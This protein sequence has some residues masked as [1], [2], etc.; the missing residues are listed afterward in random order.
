MNHEGTERDTL[1]YVRKDSCTSSGA[2]QACDFGRPNQD[3][4]PRRG[5]V[6]IDR[7]APGDYYVFVDA[8]ANF[9]EGHPYR[10][11]AEVERLEPGCVDGADNDGD[12]FIDGDDLGCAD[13]EDEDE[14]D[15]PEGAPVPACS[16]F[17][18]N[19]GDGEIDYPFDPG[20]GFKGDL[21]E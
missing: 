17:E 11:T 20:C 19:D 3:G 14:R 8:N 6:R 4:T 2:E 5:Q 7:A 1:V 18:D 16:D 15:P 9:G 13:P 12:G 10:L 21:T